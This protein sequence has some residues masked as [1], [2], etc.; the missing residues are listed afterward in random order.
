MS[1][2]ILSVEGLSK[3]FGHV[4]AVDSIDLSIDEGEVVGIIG[5]N[6]AGK[7]TFINL[8]TGTLEPTGGTVYF[9]GDDVTTLPEHERAQRGLVRSFQIPSLYDELTVLENVRGSV[10]SREGKSSRMHVPLSMDPET[11]A[12]AVEYLRYFGLESQRDVEVQHLPHGDRK[13]LDI[14]AS[15]AMDPSLI[16]LDEPTSGVGSEHTEEVMEQTIAAAEEHDISL[17]FVEHDMEIVAEFSDRV[18]AFHQGSILKDGAPE[19]VLNSEKVKEH[20]RE[21]GA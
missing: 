14:A 10:I 9:E 20:I 21:E 19:A 16:M 15:F 1:E 8:I 6:G 18:V 4:Q 17:V 7:T 13:I 5:P 11:E 12:E 2:T 3:A